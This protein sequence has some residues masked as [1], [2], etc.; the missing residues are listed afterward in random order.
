M[1]RELV[2]QKEEF[3]FI[4]VQTD[5]LANLVFSQELANQFTPNR[6]TSPG[7]KDPLFVKK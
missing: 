3:T 6:S 4:V 2:F 1:L 5:Q 7:D